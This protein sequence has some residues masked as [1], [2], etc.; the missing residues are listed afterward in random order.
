MIPAIVT[1]KIY[2]VNSLLNV[3][4]AFNDVLKEP[5]FKHME[6][7]KQFFEMQK[8]ID[9]ILISIVRGGK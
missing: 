9:D 7:H 4:K 8:Q 2:L 1:D 5:G 3:S 6:Y